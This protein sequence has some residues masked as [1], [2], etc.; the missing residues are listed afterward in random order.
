MLLTDIVFIIQKTRFL[1]YFVQERL[2]QI[3]F[4]PLYNANDYI[5]KK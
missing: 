4:I 3:D 5:I 1:R 2:V